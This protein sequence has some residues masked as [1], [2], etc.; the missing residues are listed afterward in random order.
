MTVYDLTQR[1]HAILRNF[2]IVGH[3]RYLLERFG[4]VT[5]R[6]RRE[7]AQ[8]VLAGGRGATSTGGTVGR[9]GVS[10][11]SGGSGGGA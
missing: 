4:P 2:P 10:G 5:R 7:A 3:L 1:K 8:L 9:K 6:V 11:D